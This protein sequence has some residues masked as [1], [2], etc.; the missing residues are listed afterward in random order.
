MNRPMNA[1]SIVEP[2]PASSQLAQ[3]PRAA[4]V[5]LGEPVTDSLHAEF[6]ELLEAARRA[7]DAGFLAAL[8]EWIDHTRYHFAQEEAW[9]SAM[10]FGALGCH[11]NEH[12]TVLAIA[13]R[14]RDGVANDGDLAVGRRLVAEMPGWFDLH[15]RQQDAAMVDFMRANGFSLVEGPAG[16]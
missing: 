3:L 11:R 6:A 5:Q 15:V 16:D 14:A 12:E 13:T 8:D 10:G 2:D 4:H 9:M 7:S 1:S